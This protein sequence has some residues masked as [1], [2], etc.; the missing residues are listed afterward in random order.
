MKIITIYEL[1][2]MIKDSKA[3]KEIEFNDYVFIY[4]N[5][6]NGSIASSYKHRYVDAYLFRDFVFRLSDNVRIV[7]EDKK[8]E[9]LDIE[10]A[11]SD[12]MLYKINE[13]IDHIN[14]Q[15]LPKYSMDDQVDY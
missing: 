4:T 13:I 8:I 10:L 5:E 12:D 1:L 2:G 6:D 3:P 9:K 15:E 7:E 11:S 14:K